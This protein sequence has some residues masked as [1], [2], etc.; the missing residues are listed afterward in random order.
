MILLCGYFFSLSF[1]CFVSLVNPL[2]VPFV[3][4]REEKSFTTGFNQFAFRC[5]PTADRLF[6]NPI[7]LTSLRQTIGL[8]HSCVALR[9][10][11]SSLRDPLCQGLKGLFAIE[12]SLSSNY[13][14]PFARF[15]PGN[16]LSEFIRFTGLVLRFKSTKDG[17]N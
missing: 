12:R 7:A 3:L 14:D 6:V 9:F 2:M 16:F 1:V 13:L 10:V 17:S 5:C 15:L 8:K 4:V 11:S